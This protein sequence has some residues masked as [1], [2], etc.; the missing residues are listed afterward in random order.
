MGRIK[1]FFIEMLL[2]IGY[3]FEDMSYLERIGFMFGS[4][5]MF[6]FLIEGITYLIK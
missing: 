6:D 1:L 2:F 4:I 3:M 5:C